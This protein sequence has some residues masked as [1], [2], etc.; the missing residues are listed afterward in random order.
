MD[1]TDALA[2][3]IAKIMKLNATTAG[4][5]G[6]AA[7]IV[8]ASSVGE[9]TVRQT[10][11]VALD[12]AAEF[13]NNAD[14]EALQN[15]ARELEGLLSTLQIVSVLTIQQYQALADELHGLL[16]GGSA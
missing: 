15:L 3:F 9:S 1:T 6:A 12:F 13:R 16:I 5:G 2:A 10:K 4:M 7:G 14:S 11:Q 8:G